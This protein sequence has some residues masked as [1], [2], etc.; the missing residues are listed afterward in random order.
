MELR[1]MSPKDYAKTIGV[2]IATMKELLE[3]LRA[4]AIAT[5]SL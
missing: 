5:N 1:K 2:D 3:R 4:S